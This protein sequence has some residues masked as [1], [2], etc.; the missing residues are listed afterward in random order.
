MVISKHNQNKNALLSQSAYGGIMH[1]YSHARNTFLRLALST[2]PRDPASIIERAGYR[3]PL[4]HSF[5]WC[6]ARICKRILDLRSS[7]AEPFA[8]GKGFDPD[9]GVKKKTPFK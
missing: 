2:E 3:A 1:D 7:F 5:L 4:A 6:S 9:R 8:E